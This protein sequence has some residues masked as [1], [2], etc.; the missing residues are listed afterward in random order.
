M[1]DFLQLLDGVEVCF[2]SRL[3]RALFSALLFLPSLQG[4]PFPVSHSEIPG[5]RSWCQSCLS[6]HFCSHGQ[7]RLYRIPW[8]LVLWCHRQ[9]E[10]LFL[11]I[12]YSSRHLIL[13]ARVF[14][15]QSERVHLPPPLPS[16]FSR[17]P[18]LASEQDAAQLLRQL[19]CA[20][21]AAF[22]AIAFVYRRFFSDCRCLCVHLRLEPSCRRQTYQNGISAP[23]CHEFFGL[24][25]CNAIRDFLMLFPAESS[26]H[27]W[28]PPS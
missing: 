22:R 20:S 5:Y 14:P 9:P 25:L 12:S 6:P 18:Q 3:L 28:K 24:L 1:Q 26:W 16:C 27:S 17:V 2:F 13:L 21:E 11:R 4:P 15:V 7:T 23:C 8:A 19:L 10:R